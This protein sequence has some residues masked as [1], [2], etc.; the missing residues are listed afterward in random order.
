MRPFVRAAHIIERRRAKALELAR[1]SPRAR[2]SHSVALAT[3]LALGSLG[4]CSGSDANDIGEA[5]ASLTTTCAGR[6]TPYGIIGMKWRSLGAGDGPL[7]CPLAEEQDHPE[8]GGAR[9]QNFER[10]QVAWTPGQGDTNAQAGWVDGTRLIYDFGST[11]PP[12]HYDFFLVRWDKDGRNLGEDKLV[13]NSTGGR[14]SKVV[15]DS[16][17]YRLVVEGCD[18]KGIFGS[19]CLQGWSMPVY[20]TYQPPPPDYSPRPVTLRPAPA[21]TR[22]CDSAGLSR[23]WLREYWRLGGVNGAMGCFQ[24]MSGNVA[25]FENGQISVLE[26]SGDRRVLAAFQAWDKIAIDWWVSMDAPSHT[27]DKF[28]VRWDL[29]G[30]PHSERDQVDVWAEM[31]DSQLIWGGRDT[32]SWELENG[33]AIDLQDTHLRNRG[34][35]GLGGNPALPPDRGD[36]VYVITVEGCDIRN[37]GSRC[38]QSW[39]EPVAVNFRT[40]VATDPSTYPKMAT[41]DRVNFTQGQPKSIEQA[42]STIDD[43]TA[44]GVLTLACGSILQQTDFRSEEDYTAIAAAKLAY[45]DYYGVDRCPGAPPEIS[46][47]QEVFASLL[48]QGV[49]SKSGTSMDGLLWNLGRRTGEYDA[50]L[51]GLVPILFKYWPILPPYVFDHVLF[52][53][54]NKTGGP[55]SSDWSIAP[56]IEE[57]EN[58]IWQIE[59]SRYLTNQLLFERTGDPAYDNVQNGEEAYILGRL[60]DNLRADFREYNSR[61]YQDYTTRALLNLYSYAKPGPVKTAAQMV[62]DY[63]SLKVAV[64][65]SDMRRSV[66]YRRRVSHDSDD[67]L[68]GGDVAPCGENGSCALDPMAA[69]VVALAGTTDLLVNSTHQSQMW[70]QPM[71]GAGLSDYRI[72]DTILDLIINREHRSFVQAFHH[73]TDELYAGSPSFLLSAGGQYASAAYPVG[74]FSVSDDKGLAVPTVLMPTAEFTLRSELIRFLGHT[75]DTERSNM[76]VANGFACGLRPVIPDSYLKDRERCVARADAAGNRLQGSFGPWIFLAEQGAAFRARAVGAAGQSASWIF[77]DEGREGCQRSDYPY[78]VAFHYVDDLHSA[79]FLEAVDL[80]LEPSLTFDAFVSSVLANNR[81]AHFQGEGVNTYVKHD[82]TRIGFTLYHDSRVVSAPS[83]PRLDVLAS[84]TVMNTL[85]WGHHVITN[86]ATGDEIDLDDSDVMH[87]VRTS[88]QSSP[89]G[90]R[91]CCPSGAGDVC[92]SGNNLACCPINPPNVDGVPWP[93]GLVPVCYAADGSDPALLGRARFI[94]DTYGWSA[95]ANI[96]FTGWGPC[97]GSAPASGA[98]RLHFAANTD[99]SASLRGMRPAKF[100]EVTLIDNG[101]DQR[102]ANEVL[103]QF[104]YALGFAKEQLGP[105]NESNPWQATCPRNLP[106]DGVSYSSTYRTSYDDRQSVMRRC[107][108]GPMQLSPSDVAGAQVA[109]GKRRAVANGQNSSTNA[110]ARTGANLDTFFV[111]TDGAL[112]TNY[113]Y[114]G[115]QAPNGWP[116]FALTAA[117]TAPSD[118]PVAV[119]SRSPNNIDAFYV[120]N[121]GEVLSTYWYAGGPW[122]TFA[123]PGTYGLATPGEQV[124]AVASTPGAIDVFFTGVDHNVYWSRWSGAYPTVGWTNPSRVTTDGSVPTGAAVSAVSRRPEQLD[125]VFLG[126]DGMIHTSWCFGFGRTGAT[127]CTPGNWITYT[128]PTTSACLGPPG[129]YV[130]LTARGPDNLDAF[131]ESNRRAVCTTFWTPTTTFWPSFPITAEGITSPALLNASGKIVSVARTPDNLDV[132]FIGLG[133]SYSNKLELGWIGDVYTAWWYNGAPS[134]GAADVQ[135]VLGGRGGIGSALGVTARRPDILDVFTMGYG[136]GLMSPKIISQST[137]YWTPWSNG[138]QAYV[139]DGY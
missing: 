104:G 71:T 42:K 70:V 93:G 47:R 7:G 12:F 85:S 110:V 62:L 125:L 14:W 128:T 16:G 97:L 75:E 102:F 50:A 55:D 74:P 67:F 109:Y 27:Y 4:A 135:Q 124:A 132:F 113:W 121:S 15:R 76:C 133:K 24:G 105:I 111:H 88:C 41:L 34:S 126:N 137:A 29:Q 116:T 73:N 6:P 72:P 49:G 89:G 21:P 118:A 95:V 94:L 11:L 108:D 98:I 23:E 9:I 120:S 129:G 112:W 22:H 138:W 122:T 131:W 1:R 35:L 25:R 30:L 91:F 59:S 127:S 8:G 2:A 57:T 106:Y 32:Q 56:T 64:S 87:P 5:A 45:A 58:H 90:G 63:L 115:I 139:T 96:N 83:M 53:L 37:T 134:W 31:S 101:T 117:N 61:P 81:G 69:R 51:A 19:R 130:A 20:L 79:G 48:G 26:D 114:E 103:K 13:G 40:P 36:G 3:A 17:V 28:L 100:T 82:G 119:V 66:P 123:L 99:G 43:R 39:F 46:L 33:K 54:L 80:K 44:L 84:G 136:Y 38:L 107:S 18:D 52:N 60:G 10:G 92:A 86:P 65:S 78:F 68:G 77:F